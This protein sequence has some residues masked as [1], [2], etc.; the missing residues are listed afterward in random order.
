MRGRAAS[1]TGKSVQWLGS[2]L[3]EIRDR[4][5]AA[6]WV[7]GDLVSLDATLEANDRG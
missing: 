6:V 3:F 1:P 7:L 2:T 4:Q 5:I